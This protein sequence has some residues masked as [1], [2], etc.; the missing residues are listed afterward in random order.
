M[1]TRDNVIVL[2]PEAPP[3]QSEETVEAPGRLK[4]TDLKIG[5][6]DNG[7]GNADHLLRFVLKGL[8][9][10]V[11]IKAPITQRKANVSLAAQ[12][13]I[14]DRYAAESDLVITAMAD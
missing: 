5:F 9:D 12:R 6:L 3:P 4:A 7:K 10:E 14:L 8:E 2:I 1:T 11:K 13:E